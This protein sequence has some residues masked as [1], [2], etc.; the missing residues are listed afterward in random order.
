M[1]TENYPS[2]VAAGSQTLVMSNSNSSGQIIYSKAHLVPP[3]YEGNMLLVQIDPE[4]GCMEVELFEY[5]NLD[6]LFYLSFQSNL[7]VK[8]GSR[9]YFM[10]NINI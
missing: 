7:Y 6:S 4:T 8:H 3:Q 9:I 10:F 1:S 2:K 5:K